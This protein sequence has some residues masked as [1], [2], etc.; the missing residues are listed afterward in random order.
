MI[1]LADGYYL[2]T[3]DY[4]Y[5]LCYGTPKVDKMGKTRHEIVGYYGSLGKAIEACRQELIHN[6]IQGVDTDLVG[7]CQAIREITDEFKKLMEERQLA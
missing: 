1:K 5:V 7:A 2:K 6:Y 4:G 3:D